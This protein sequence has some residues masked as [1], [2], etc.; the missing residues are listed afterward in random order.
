MKQH[1]SL[2]CLHRNR[3]WVPYFVLLVT[4]LLTTFATYYV[5]RTAKAKEELR[6]EK[7]VQSREQKRSRE[8]TQ[9]NYRLDLG[10]R[11][12]RPQNKDVA[13][14]RRTCTEDTRYLNVGF[15]VGSNSKRSLN[16]LFLLTQISCQQSRSVNLSKVV[17]IITD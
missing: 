8:T 16:L 6:F 11:P 4:L 7:A 17:E 10:Y 5:A 2:Q 1:L 3:T 14:E 12:S 9:K 15:P 13:Y